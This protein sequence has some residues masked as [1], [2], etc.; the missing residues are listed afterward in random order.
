MC[1]ER[2]KGILALTAYMSLTNMHLKARHG[3]ARNTT[4][5]VPCST[6]NLA[7]SVWTLA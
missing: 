6:V 3:Q 1:R 4:P 2:T 5:A 7:R